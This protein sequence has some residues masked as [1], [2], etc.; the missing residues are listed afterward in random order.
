MLFPASFKPAS[1]AVTATTASGTTSP[2]RL[3]YIHD[4]E[5]NMRFLIDTGAAI[6][7][8]PPPRKCQLRP[9]NFSLQA[10]N[11]SLIRTFG[12]RSLTLELG[13]R[14]RFPWIFVI[15]D[16]Q[17]PI[18]GADFLSHYAIN[19][20]VRRRQLI[21]TT[22]SL[23]VVGTQAQSFSLGIKVAVPCESPICFGFE[24]V[25]FTYTTK[26]YLGSDQ[27]FN[28]TPHSHTWTPCA[29]QT[30]TTPPRQT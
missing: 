1:Q 26:Q 14:R 8:I 16:V 22:T 12:E 2:C 21:D 28:R 15:A 25:S 5:C 27:T 7:V 11:N 6:S 9:T 24:G 10:A 17:T 19:V 13:L 30:S 29:R 3:F 23:S 20:D 18:I 4:R